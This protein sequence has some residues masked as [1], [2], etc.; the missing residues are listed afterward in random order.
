LFENIKLLQ[1]FTDINNTIYVLMGDNLMAIDRIS[2]NTYPSVSSTVKANEQ[3][4]NQTNVEK[5]EEQTNQGLQQERKISKEY[6]NKTVQG[7]NEFLLPSTTSLK[8][9]VHEESEEY[10]VQVID[11]R[12]KEV[13][14]Q[15]PNQEFLD[16]YAAMKDVLGLVVDEKA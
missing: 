16:M 3:Q 6:L 12:T 4:Q 15:I 7:I 9:Q 2:S 1:K 13:I 8:F 5:K 11:D 10:Y 14:R